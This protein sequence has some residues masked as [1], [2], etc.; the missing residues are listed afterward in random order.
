MGL[1][2]TFLPLLS[3]RRPY[4]WVS[5]SI[6][7][8]G[9]GYNLE[10]LMETLKQKDIPEPL[11]CYLARDKEGEACYGQVEVDPYG[12]AL[13]FVLAGDLARLMTPELPK[14]YCVDLGGFAYLQ[15]RNP[16]LPVVLYWS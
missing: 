6:I 1:S 12:G 9:V 2:L 16:E 4:Y 10:T 15:H 3:A 11:T 8:A 14:E 5:H 13:Q 7:P